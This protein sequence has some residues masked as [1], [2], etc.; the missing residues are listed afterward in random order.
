MEMAEVQLEVTV[1]AARQEN[2][3]QL[4]ALQAVRGANPQRRAGVREL[5]ATWYYQEPV[6]CALRSAFIVE[7]N[8]RPPRRLR[9]S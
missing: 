5:R 1:Q 8:Y 6:R 9:F 7:L 3:A 4:P 2:R